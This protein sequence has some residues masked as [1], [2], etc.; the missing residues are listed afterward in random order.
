MPL[1]S[2]IWMKLGGRDC[3]WAET[4]KDG[5][6]PLPLAEQRKTKDSV[7]T[8]KLET[9]VDNQ[10]LRPCRYMSCANP[11]KNNPKE[12]RSQNGG[13]TSSL[14]RNCQGVKEGAM[15]FVV[16]AAP[17][18]LI[19]YKLLTLCGLLPGQPNCDGSLRSNWVKNGV[20][21]YQIQTSIRC[22]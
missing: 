20:C 19:G 2:I 7:E 18:M 4:E 22:K 5:G 11:K 1:S 15:L 21:K 6:L 10:S 3:G 16:V 9:N 14:F 12:K 13:Q 17:A 8:R